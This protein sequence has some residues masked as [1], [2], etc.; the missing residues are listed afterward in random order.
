MVSLM[1]IRRSGRKR[2]AARPEAASPRTFR[3]TEPRQMHALA[4]PLRLRLLG[5]LRTAGPA[6]A[7]TLARRLDVSTP[8]ASYHL[9]QLSEHGFIE[10]S[11]DHAA[12]GRERWW[13]S[14]HESTSFSKAD[15]LDTPER[16]GA[17]NAL[18]REMARRY[19]DATEAWLEDAPSWSRA[20]VDAADM[21]DWVVELTAPE[22]R[23]M[24]KELAAVV[25]RWSGRPKR[26]GSEQVRAIVQVFPR[27]RGS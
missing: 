6:T 16:L 3:L 5:L 7:T 10:E 4:H 18:E 11:P 21:S 23:S 9:R 22:L 8:L 19:L 20:W 27:R 26:P 1:V 15:W 17:A 14:R 12:D 13:R 25:E 2:A 24:R